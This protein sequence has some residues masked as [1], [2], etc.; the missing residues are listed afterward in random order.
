VDAHIRRELDAVRL[1]TFALQ[2]VGQHRLRGH[3]DLYAAGGVTEVALDLRLV[4]S[5]PGR[6][7]VAAQ[8]RFPRGALGLR[9]LGPVATG[10]VRFVLAVHARVPEPVTRRSRRT[11]AGAAA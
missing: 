4:E 8:G 2:A 6:V 3:A 1:E 9:R 5:S 7:R 10:A 11:A